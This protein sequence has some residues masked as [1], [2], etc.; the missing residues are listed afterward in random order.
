SP[1]RIAALQHTKLGRSGQPVAVGVVE[2][3]LLGQAGEVVD[4]AGRLAVVQLQPDGALT[5][6][7]ARADEGRVSRDP[8]VLRRLD[9]L[10][11]LL[12]GRW[13]LAIGDQRL[14]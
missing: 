11:R 3:S 13:I 10:A 4:G 6:G 12:R 2:E 7:D 9:G 5:D 8:T 1:G 14:R